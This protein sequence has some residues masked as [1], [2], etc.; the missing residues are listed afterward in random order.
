[1]LKTMPFTS[2]SSES[3]TSVVLE[4]AKLAVSPGPLGT[5]AG[6]QLAAVFQSP[7]VGLRFQVA[8][9]PNAVA[10]ARSR[11][12]SVD[13]ADSEQGTLRRSQ[14]AWLRQIL[15]DEVVFAS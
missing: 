7:L 9:P 5:V 12:K 14:G 15:R 13:I 1:V 10:A 2:M 4:L 8:L 11:E 6:V 3:E